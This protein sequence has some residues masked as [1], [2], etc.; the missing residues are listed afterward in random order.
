MATDN[1][2]NNNE[3]DLRTKIALKVLIIM[4]K[5]I[6]P[7]KFAHQFQADIEKL[8]KDIYGL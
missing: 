3:I 5:V 1:W 2:E 4:F 7:Y 6:S 8:E